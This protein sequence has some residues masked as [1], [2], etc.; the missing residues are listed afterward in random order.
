MNSH[1]VVALDAISRYAAIEWKSD[2]GT[3][4]A[5][6]LSKEAFTD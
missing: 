1:E 4:M 2:S 5:F 3:I 6:S